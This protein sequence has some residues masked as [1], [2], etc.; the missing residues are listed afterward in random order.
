MDPWQYKVSVYCLIGSKPLDMSN[1]VCRN[2][3]VEGTSLDTGV[4]EMRIKSISGLMVHFD[5][6]D[7]DDVLTNASMRKAVFT[8]IF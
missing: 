8:L 3:D 7:M 6:Q 2:A 1:K 5:E 4:K